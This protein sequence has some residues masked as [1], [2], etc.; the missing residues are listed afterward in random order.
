MRVPQDDTNFGIGTL[1]RADIC[2]TP[3]TERLKEHLMLDL[4]MLAIALGFFALSVGYTIAC[5]RL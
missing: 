3:P 2:R 5:D 4:I 1:A